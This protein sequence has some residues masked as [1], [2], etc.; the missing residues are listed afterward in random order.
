MTADDPTMA[1]IHEAVT[2]HHEGDPAAARNRL[3]ALWAEI[4][5]DGDPFHQCVLAHHLADTQDDPHQELLWDQRALAA[6]DSVTDARV[7]EHH[8]SLAIRGF[9][10]SLHL[11]LA[12]SYR[13]T[14]D[15]A[16]ARE[17]LAHARAFTGAL[18]DDP[19]GHGIRAALDRLADRLTD[20]LTQPATCEDPSRT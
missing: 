4:S 1:R 5:P 20:R 12:E 16:R 8:S 18:G 6:A 19:Y 13:R 10:P 11:N 17:H 14:G 15:P 9:Y 3:D 2:L 7:K